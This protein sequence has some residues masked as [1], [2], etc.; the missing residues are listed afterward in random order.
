MS[1]DRNPK[2]GADSAFS[3]GARRVTDFLWETSQGDPSSFPSS[4]LE[5]LRHEF[6]D[7][8]VSMLELI[9]RVDLGP[10]ATYEDYCE[11]VES[12]LCVE[13]SSWPDPASVESLSGN[14]LKYE[15]EPSEDFSE[16]D[17]ENFA[18]GDMSSKMEQFL[19]KVI[20]TVYLDG[21]GKVT[22]NEGKPPNEENNFL[23]SDD[24]KEFS[25]VFFDS[26]R[27]KEKHYPFVISDKGNGQWKI[28]Y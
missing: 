14:R 26:Q 19:R 3:E 9:D 22:D 23:L 20:G 7:G 6:E 10:G 25:G 28:K 1:Y 17:T 5:T 13:S 12:L 11:V 4:Y 24:G 16:F 27:P 21:V 2:F 15:L 8:R 18:E